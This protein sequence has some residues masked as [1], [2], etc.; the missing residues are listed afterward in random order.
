M[1]AINH[2]FNSYLIKVRRVGIDSI[3]FRS[4]FHFFTFFFIWM[5]KSIEQIAVNVWMEYLK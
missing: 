5:D 2:I 3:G 1:S 4:L